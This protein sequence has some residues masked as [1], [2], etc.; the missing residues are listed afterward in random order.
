MS[1]ANEHVQTENMYLMLHYL[2]S[3]CSHTP[4]HTGSSIKFELENK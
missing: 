1:V 4:K 2:H 3:I